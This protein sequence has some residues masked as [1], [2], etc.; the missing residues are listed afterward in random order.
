MY[1]V[2][3]AGRPGLKPF[4]LCTDGDLLSLIEAIV[5]QRSADTVLIS[6]VE[7]HAHE[8]MVRTG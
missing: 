3:L 4:E 1:L 2:F 6:Q 7:G 5:R 8:E